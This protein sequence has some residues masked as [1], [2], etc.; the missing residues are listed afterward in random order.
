[1]LNDVI[2]AFVNQIVAEI[3]WFNANNCKGFDDETV[4]DYILRND[5]SP[6]P[7]CCMI[8]S[9]GGIRER[10]QRSEFG[11]GRLIDWIIILT[12]LFPISGSMND[13]VEQKENVYE[14]IDKII[15]MVMKDNTL[16]GV[17]MDTEIYDAEPLMEY[18]RNGANTFL[19]LS[20]RFA[21]AEN[22]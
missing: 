19:L 22:L 3:D 16:G 14:L 21:V 15:E 4:I 5:L 1:M 6:K 10:S 2:N 8:V 7:Q 20:M 13:I 17:V 9:Y 11:G 18:V 12:A